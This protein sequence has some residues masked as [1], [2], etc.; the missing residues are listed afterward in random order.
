MQVEIVEEVIEITE[1]GLQGPRG[2]AA[3]GAITPINFSWGDASPALLVT[4]GAGK[5]VYVVE[6]LIT[7]E[8]DGVGA[9][10][11]VGPLA[12]PAELMATGENDPTTI[13]SYEATPD[14][15]YGAATAIYL[16]ITPGAGASAGS[17][18][19]R[20]QIEA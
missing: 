6:I 2:V 19:V 7:E 17:G 20:V 9:A 5:R 12:A 11:S 1:V 4:V 18:Q 8:F 14:K 3:I 16:T 10:L 15:F 13:A